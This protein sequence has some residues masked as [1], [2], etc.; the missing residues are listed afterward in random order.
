VDTVVTAWHAALS[1]A[2]QPRGKPEPDW[3]TVLMPPPYR[4]PRTPGP[5]PYRNQAPEPRCRCGT[6]CRRPQYPSR[7]A[8]A[9]LADPDRRHRRRERRTVTPGRRKPAMPAGGRTPS[10]PHRCRTSSGVR[11]RRLAGHAAED[12]ASCTSQAARLDRGCPRLGALAGRLP[13]LEAA[14]MGRSR[15]YPPVG[16]RPRLEPGPGP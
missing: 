15:P 8:P 13:E 1:R 6:S 14:W 9:P 16:S 3:T 4:R 10:H 2:F 5:G 12:T 7:G 11:P